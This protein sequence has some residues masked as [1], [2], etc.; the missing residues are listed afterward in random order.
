VTAES[1]PPPEHDPPMGR[2]YALVVI[3]HIA[4]ITLL[5]WIGRVFSS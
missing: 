2:T 4:T 5:W 1:S 3:C